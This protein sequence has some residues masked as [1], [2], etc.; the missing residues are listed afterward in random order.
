MCRS[1]VGIER[2]L[3][4]ALALMSLPLAGRAQEPSLA[5]VLARATDYVDKLHD[6]LSGTVAEERYEQRA[7]N[8]ATVGFGDPDRR[9]VLRSDFLLIRPEGEGRYYGFR[10]VFE[11]DDRVV[12][13]RQDR[14]SRLFLKP[15][16]STSRQIAG[17]RNDSARY[18]IGGIAR[19]FNTPT[20][21]LLFLSASYKPRF[22]F[23]RVTDMSP[24]LGLEG[25]ADNAD[26]WVLRYTE[27]WPISVIRGRDGENL[28]AEGRFWI[29]PTTGRVLVTE[30][31]VDS[32]DVD[33]TIT[34]RY[35]ETETIDHLVPVEMRE[36][37][38]SRRQGSRV[39]GTATYSR[40]RRFQVEVGVSEPFRE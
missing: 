25:P 26:I 9:R 14:L 6:Q 38:D 39:D 4:V 22:E 10:D 5:D 16:A 24:A 15:S 36:R 32:D 17:I 3:L 20:Y 7:R 11:V 31:I 8:P 18:N 2:S 33:A 27:T 1:H 28:P 34:V 21:A 40:F 23:E 30:L 29:E 13:D 19:N 12:R 35:A 37:Y